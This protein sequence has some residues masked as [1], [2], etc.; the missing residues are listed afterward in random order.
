[1]ATHAVPRVSTIP[2]APSCQTQQLLGWKAVC[3]TKHRVRQWPT[4]PSTCTRDS[5]PARRH[6]RQRRTSEHEFA[7]LFGN[8]P[9]RKKRVAAAHADVDQETGGN[10]ALAVH[11]TPENRSQR[12][13]SVHSEVAFLFV[14]RSALSSNEDT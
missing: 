12:H 6:L 1:V 11:N 14:E 5:R 3:F 8:S 10:L 13:Q 2:L 9:G 4:S 7:R